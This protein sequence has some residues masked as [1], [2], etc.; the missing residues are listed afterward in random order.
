MTEHAN[1]LSDSCADFQA[2]KATDN[3][4]R[5]S[6]RHLDK[7]ST[8]RGA[9]SFQLVHKAE[10]VKKQLKYV[11]MSQNH[12]NDQFPRSH[13]QRQREEIPFQLDYQPQRFSGRRADVRDSS[14]LESPLVQNGFRPGSIAVGWTR[15]SIGSHRRPLDT[16]QALRPVAGTDSGIEG[17][18]LLDQVFGRGGGNRGITGVDGHSDFVALG[19]DVVVGHS[20][21]P[22]RAYGIR[23]RSWVTAASTDIE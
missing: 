3:R 4:S 1:P 16:L 17:L 10:A 20:R 12:N 5:E 19:C 6:D 8:T 2:I 18:L 21:I 23:V 13:I 14:E 7:I 15:G 11:I 22:C 9:S